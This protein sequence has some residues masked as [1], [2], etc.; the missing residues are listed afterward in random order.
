[1]HR[2][3]PPRAAWGA[4][5]VPGAAWPRPGTPSVAARQLPRKRRSQAPTGQVSAAASVSTVEGGKGTN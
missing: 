3:S 2:R 4:S 1:M 5:P